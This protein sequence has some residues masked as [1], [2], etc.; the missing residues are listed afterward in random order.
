MAAYQKAMGIGQDIDPNFT[1]DHEK[2]M[3]LFND[4]QAALALNAYEIN[5][6][7]ETISTDLSRR[8]ESLGK[9]EKQNESIDSSLTNM[10]SLL[11]KLL[12]SI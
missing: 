7:S 3:R 6:I 1:Y 5:Q 9:I 10:E 12:E 4:T 2:Q 11:S 8:N